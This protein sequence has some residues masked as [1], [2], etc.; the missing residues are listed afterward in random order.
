MNC[1]IVSYTFSLEHLLMS[2]SVHISFKVISSNLFVFGM[3]QSNCNFGYRNYFRLDTWDVFCLRFYFNHERVQI[4][5]RNLCS[6]S[7][8]GCAE[9][10]LMK[11]K[12]K[13]TCVGWKKKIMNV[14]QNRRRYLRELSKENL[15]QSEHFWA[16]KEQN[17]CCY[18]TKLVLQM[19]VLWNKPLS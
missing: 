11:G 16:S 10:C 5:G 15:R 3:L 13:R 8:G 4:S 1:Q 6:V 19:T 18:D 9:L 12:N 17:H 14:F 7:N 2:A